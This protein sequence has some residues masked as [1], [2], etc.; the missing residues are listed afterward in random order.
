MAKYLNI[1]EAAQKLGMERS[2]L[3]KLRER[4]EIRAFAD[5]GNWKF[6]E[7]D[8][9]KLKR[10]RQEDSSPDVRLHAPATGNDD[11]VEISALGSDDDISE[12]PTIVRRGSALGDSSDSDVRLIREDENADDDATNVFGDSDSDVRLSKD[13]KSDKLKHQQLAQRDSEVH[14]DAG[15]SDSHVKI[16]GS[17]GSDSD[18]K[19]VGKPKSG[20]VKPG[21]GLKKGD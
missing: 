3:N 2:E 19:L 8:V 15:D 13:P 20:V 6:R 5:R 1:D 12:Q 11:T 16:A 18:V 4:G 7:E 17:T 10:S 9:D 14:L 21:S